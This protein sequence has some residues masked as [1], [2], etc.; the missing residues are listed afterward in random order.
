MINSFELAIYIV[1]I[2]ILLLCL[3]FAI[4]YIFDFRSKKILKIANKMKL[5]FKAG[6]TDLKNNYVSGTIDGKSI[7][8]FDIYSSM[9]MWRY[10][11]NP[12]SRPASRSFIIIDQN[13]FEFP[14]LISTTQIEQLI[15]DC[16]EK[17]VTNGVKPYLGR[18]NMSNYLMLV[19]FII[20]SA[21][22][23][24]QLVQFASK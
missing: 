18:M 1:G 14:K 24:F 12:E 13:T 21:I 11:S 23:I 2:I 17:G 9:L 7:I 16:I 10:F 6:T 3:Y 22:L 4:Y 15:Y 5:G 20:I 8:Y 19:I